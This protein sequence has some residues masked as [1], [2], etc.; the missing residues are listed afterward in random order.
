MR[1]TDEIMISRLEAKSTT[2][3]GVI[4]VMVPSLG[5]ALA[6][7]SIGSQLSQRI[8]D[9]TAKLDEG[10]PYNFEGIDIVFN[11]VNV[12]IPILISFSMGI[13][14]LATLRDLQKELHIFINNRKEI[15]NLYKNMINDAGDRK[16]TCGL[17]CQPLGRGRSS[18]VLVILSILLIKILP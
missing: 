12:F 13:F 14:L 2:F 11:Q 1:D 10:M 16:L 9:A 4:G 18:L 8:V 15:D 7:F 3:L 6:L 17:K 5:A